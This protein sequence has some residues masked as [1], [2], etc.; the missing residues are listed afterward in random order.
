MKTRSFNF[1][2][3]DVA[4]AQVLIE[5]CFKLRADCSV[6]F[7]PGCLTVSAM[8]SDEENEAIL[9]PDRPTTEKDWFALGRAA[10]LRREAKGV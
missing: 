7:Y 5:K 6:N 4:A 10:Q 8:L 9:N 2:T 1:R 3:T